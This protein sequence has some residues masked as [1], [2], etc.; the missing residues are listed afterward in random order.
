MQNEPPDAT[1]FASNKRR[2]LFVTHPGIVPLLRQTYDPDHVYP[3]T[4]AEFVKFSTLG[5][6]MTGHG[7]V[8][9]PQHAY[10]E[11]F[12]HRIAK[13][14]R[15]E[16]LYH[17]CE[18]PSETESNILENWW[19]T[20]L[21]IN[22]GATP[23]IWLLAGPPNCHDL[24]WSKWLEHDC[25]MWPDNHWSE[26]L[27]SDKSWVT[28]RWYTNSVA[29]HTLLGIMNEE[30]FATL[31]DELPD[32]NFPQYTE[33]ARAVSEVRKVEDVTYYSVSVT[34]PNDY[35][36]VA[37]F[38]SEDESARTQ[39]ALDT[40]PE[41]VPDSTTT[42]VFYTGCRDNIEMF[43]RVSSPFEVAPEKSWLTYVIGPHREE[44]PVEQIV[45]QKVEGML[46]EWV[47]RGYWVPILEFQTENILNMCVLVDDKGNIQDVRNESPLRSHNLLTIRSESSSSAGISLTLTNQTV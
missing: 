24:V 16:V 20:K 21:P 17:H 25:Y 40:Q 14:P 37:L 35:T 46:D 7:F 15:A 47:E 43:M 13:D 3:Q 10:N 41:Q 11:T 6:Y 12:C 8:V 1:S 42:R 45:E 39:I 31:I 18:Y 29:M 19:A 22:K 4:I 30:L 44:P 2:S 28:N 33:F 34:H 36:V 38:Q 27:R 5:R 32:Q 9:P 23:K 26:Q